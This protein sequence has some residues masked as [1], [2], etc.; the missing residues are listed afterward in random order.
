MLV[1][2]IILI[3]FIQM[4]KRSNL[5]FPHEC[6]LR[7]KF[8]IY[9][10]PIALLP[11]LPPSINANTISQW[12][13]LW[14][15]TPNNHHNNLQSFPGFTNPVVY[16]G[17]GSGWRWWWRWC[18]RCV[19]FFGWEKEKDRKRCNLRRRIRCNLV[20]SFSSHERPWIVS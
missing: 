18:R 9:L 7:I 14:L 15:L 3:K 10:Q 5:F 19:F 8:N 1:L 20:D 12:P 13:P 17:G 6:W 16:I 11:A 2:E 4:F